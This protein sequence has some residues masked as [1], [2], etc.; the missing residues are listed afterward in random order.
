MCIR[1]RGKGGRLVFAAIR[2][3]STK[4][5]ILLSM[6]QMIT[7]MG[8]VF[9]LTWPAQFQEFSDG[10]AVVNVNP[11]SSFSWRCLFVTYRWCGRPPAA[12]GA[13]SHVY[14]CI[15]HGVSV[16]CTPCS[17]GTTASSA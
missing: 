7:L 10:L 15:L 1:D 4:V 12:C 6:V 8:G 9:S 5:V 2:V 17:A 14:I 3:A 13:S 11:V 16:A